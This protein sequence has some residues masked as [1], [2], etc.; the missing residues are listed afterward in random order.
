MVKTANIKN[1]I[2]L[3]AQK[4]AKALEGFI[5][6]YPEQW[7]VFKRFDNNEK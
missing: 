2:R 7:F 1:D 4:L 3:N 5:L 6:K